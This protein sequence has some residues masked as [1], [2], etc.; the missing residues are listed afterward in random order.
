M[1]LKGRLETRESLDLRARRDRLDILD[2]MDSGE[3]TVG[4]ECQSAIR[5]AESEL[6]AANP[7][8]RRLSL[9][10]GAVCSLKDPGQSFHELFEEVRCFLG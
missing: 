8:R 2:E 5:T 6:A 7:Q 3:A 4:R 9:V 10:A 1:E